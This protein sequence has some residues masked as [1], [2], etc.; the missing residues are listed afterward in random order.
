MIEAG[1]IA[2]A[3]IAF[4]HALEA[5]GID[6]ETVE[7]RLPERGWRQLAAAVARDAEAMRRAGDPQAELVT[8][9]QGRGFTI[10]RV[11]YLIRYD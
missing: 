3:L 7:V 9:D 6:L 2:E 10:E 4:A 5:E 11:S 8:S 1:P